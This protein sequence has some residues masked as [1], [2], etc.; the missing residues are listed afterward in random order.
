[1]TV[2]WSFQYEAFG[3]NIMK[4]AFHEKSELIGS[5][6]QLD[7]EVFKFSEIGISTR[8]EVFGQCT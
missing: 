5:L 4:L 6:G 3:H 2:I 1:M 8:L 7:L